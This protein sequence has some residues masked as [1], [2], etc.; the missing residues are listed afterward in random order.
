M[1]TNN[2]M[3]KYSKKPS[4]INALKSLNLRRIVCFPRNRHFAIFIVHC[5]KSNCK[6]SQMLVEIVEKSI[7][8]L[9]EKTQNEYL[10][11]FKTL[12]PNDIKS[13][14]KKEPMDK[15]KYI[16]KENIEDDGC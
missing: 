5:L 1:P 16:R 7:E 8:Q 6:R 9:P 2:Y 10:E 15:R 12:T 11:I 13:I 3:K 14:G 4:T